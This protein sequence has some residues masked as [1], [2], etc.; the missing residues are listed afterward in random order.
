MSI[1]KE[2]VIRAENISKSFKI[3]LDK[4]NELKTNLFNAVLGK[5]SGYREFQALKDISFSV[6]EGDFFGIVGR[7]G[8]GKSTLLKILSQI[9]VPTSGKVHVRGSLMPFIELGV[10]F[11]PK[12]TARENVYLNGAMIGFSRKEV[13]D[14]YD[15][16]VDFAELHDFMEEKLKNF[17]SGMKVRLAFSIAIRA[18]SEIL[19]LDEVLAVGDKAFREKCNDFFKAQKGKRTII[20][21]THDMGAVEEFCNKAMFIEGGNVIKIGDSDEIADLY[22]D[23]FAKEKISK[24]QE[25]N[26][27]TI[28]NTSAE[29]DYDFSLQAMYI[30]QGGKKTDLVKAGESFSVV[31]EYNVPRDYNNA[32]TGIKILNTQNLSLMTASLRQSGEIHKFKKGKNKAIFHVDNVFT[33]GDYR[34]NITAKDIDDNDRLLFQQSSACNFSI[35]GIQWYASSLV[36]PEVSVKLEHV[37]Q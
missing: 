9:Y 10:G 7:N 20:L 30:Q 31:I 5:K 3:P 34:I 11:N 25:K 24:L 4:S 13:D 22:N 29:A 6:N 1:S 16:I 26:K 15:E 14:I 28:E 35:T 27:N 17:S 37:V 36:H 23:M 32:T 19:L 21:V 8:S 12:L 33:D 2:P 18:P